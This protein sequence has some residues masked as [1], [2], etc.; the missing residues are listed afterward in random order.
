VGVET[1]LGRSKRGFFVK[2]RCF[3][4]WSETV[5]N[6]LKAQHVSVLTHSERCYIQKIQAYGSHVDLHR[7]MCVHMY[8]L[9]TVYNLHKSH[10]YSLHAGS[11]ALEPCTYLSMFTKT[12]AARSL[13]IDRIYI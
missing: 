11:R 12:T 13:N 6:L 7:Y 1:L 10:P 5:V 4:T 8:T 3:P 9:Y 2:A